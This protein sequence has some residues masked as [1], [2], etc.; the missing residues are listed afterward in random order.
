MKRLLPLCLAL[1]FFTVIAPQRTSAQVPGT[2]TLQGQLFQTNGEPVPD[3]TRSVRVSFHAGAN[4]DDFISV[5]DN[6]TTTF[7]SGVFTL[8]LGGDTAPLP[9]MTRPYWVELSIDGAPL[10]PRL[11]I[12]SVPYA[13]GAPGSPPIGSITA[14]AGKASAVPDGWMA[15][16]GT[17]LDS[18]SYAGIFSVLGTMWGD[19]SNDSSATTDFNLPDLR[20]MFMRGADDG[21]VDAYASYRRNGVS[22]EAYTTDQAV[23][24]YHGDESGYEGSPSVK[25]SG[26]MPNRISMNAT[27]ANDRQ[28]ALRIPNAAVLYIIRV[29]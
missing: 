19:G 22:R 15:C 5:C 25:L 23:G 1:L 7:V 11:Q 27:A 20:G 24:T 4:T 16:D 14:F 13:L 2:I 29:R 10:Q 26:G 9:P 6:C 12:H 3:G 18:R 28:I 17:A 21:V 8:V